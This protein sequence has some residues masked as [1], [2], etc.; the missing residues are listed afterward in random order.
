M[1]IYKATNKVNGKIYVGQS[2]NSLKERIKGGYGNSLFQRAL[3]K[4]GK[5]LFQWE[6]LWEGVC[7]KVFLNE[8]EKYYIYFWDSYKTGYNMTMGGES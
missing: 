3:N 4:Y 8:L 1:I 7:S 6:I 2:T 5:D